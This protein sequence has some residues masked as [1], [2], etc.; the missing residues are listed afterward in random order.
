MD[1]SKRE[2]ENEGDGGTTGVPV[3]TLSDK[4]TCIQRLK[5]R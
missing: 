2:K 1:N 3:Q 5:G 4:R